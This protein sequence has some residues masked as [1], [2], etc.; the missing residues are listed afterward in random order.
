M[1]T[2]NYPGIDYAAGQPVNRNLET[3]LRY[4]IIPSHSVN[5]DA[6]EDIYSN[7]TDEDFETFKSEVKKALRGAL[8]DYFSDYKRSTGDSSLDAAVENAFDAI[9]DDLNCESTGD[10]T[11]CSY[12]SDGYKLQS[13][14]DGAMQN[15]WVLESPYFTYAQ[16]CSPCAP[17]A[18]YLNSPLGEPAEA[19][20][21]YC[22]GHDWFNAD[23]PCPY[24]VYSIKTG[25][26]VTA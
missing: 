2:T 5:P 4:G 20:K 23:S 14:S 21:C 26:L 9:S 12:E 8:S 15:L 17:G 13:A 6:L 10:C 7:G 22:L 18:C 19:N 11:R 1:K 25:E 3:G 16:F 24:P